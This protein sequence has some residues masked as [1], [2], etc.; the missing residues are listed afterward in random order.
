MNRS[1]K[2]I[3]GSGRGRQGLQLAGKHTNTG[4]TNQLQLAALWNTDAKTDGPATLTVRCFGATCLSAVSRKSFRLR[5]VPCQ[6]LPSLRKCRFLL[7]SHLA[8][9]ATGLQLYDLLN[10]ILHS[11]FHSTLHLRLRVDVSVEPNALA[12]AC[13][14]ALHAKGPCLLRKQTPASLQRR[15]ILALQTSEPIVV[16]CSSL[17]CA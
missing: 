2:T 14:K 4:T 3:D 17:L 16:H 7:N 10:K 11:A 13:V 8:F 6:S 12:I 9:T 15:Q 5:S 1:T